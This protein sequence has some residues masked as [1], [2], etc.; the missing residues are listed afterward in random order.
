MDERL[1]RAA[2]RALADGVVAPLVAGAA[3]V[4]A[5]LVAAVD[6]AAGGADRVAQGAP[7]HLSA[8]PEPAA[9]AVLARV[10]PR[11]LRLSTVRRSLRT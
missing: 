10:A 7:Q 11:T 1:G 6:I 9:A 3:L 8:A 5:D 4:G 2:H